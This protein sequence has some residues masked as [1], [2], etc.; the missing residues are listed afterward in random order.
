LEFFVRVTLFNLFATAA[1]EVVGGDFLERNFFRRYFIV[2]LR[3]LFDW[4]NN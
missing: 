3:L 2:V 1:E 4:R